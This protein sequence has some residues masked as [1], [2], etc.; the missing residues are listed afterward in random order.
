MPRFIC[1]I[2]ACEE[3][4]ILCYYLCIY[5]NL[6]IFVKRRMNVTGFSGSLFTEYKNYSFSFNGVTD[7]HGHRA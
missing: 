1:D 6:N 7:C 5:L 4:S 3:L 2:F